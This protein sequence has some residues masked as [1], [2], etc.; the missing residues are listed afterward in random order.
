MGKNYKRK[1]RMQIQRTIFSAFGQPGICCALNVD[2][3]SGSEKLFLSPAAQEGS[4]A[5]HYQEQLMRLVEA[6][7]DAGI[8]HIQISHMNAY[9]I[10]KGSVTLAAS[11]MTCPPPI[12]SIA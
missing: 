1:I 4:A 12:P 2:N 9:D 10:Q 8:H 5:C 6:N 3:F 7:M 11:G